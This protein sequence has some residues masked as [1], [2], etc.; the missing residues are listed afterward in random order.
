MSTTFSRFLAFGTTM[1]QTFF[2]PR[3][4]KW[5]QPPS[6]ERPCSKHILALVTLRSHNVKVAKTPK[7]VEKGLAKFGTTPLKTFLCSRN[8][9][10]AQPRSCESP[11][12]FGTRS[13][14]TLE[15][16]DKLWFTSEYNLVVE[17][18]VWNDS[19]PNI[20]GHS[21]PRLQG[22]ESPT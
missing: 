15:T 16:K 19:V 22:C 11:K 12:M 20:C 13:F 14:S 21:Q 5:A 7:S 2:G 9:E 1:C 17:F 3:R 18:R 4:P 10:S 6:L 8:P